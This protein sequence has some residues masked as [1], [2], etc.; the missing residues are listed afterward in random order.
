M[1]KFRCIRP[2]SVSKFD[3]EIDDF[4]E[5]EYLEVEENSTWELD[6]ESYRVDSNNYRLTNDNAEWIELDFY[7]LN[8]HFIEILE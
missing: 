3:E 1:K 4:I 5:D 6:F 7:L 8:K 2:F